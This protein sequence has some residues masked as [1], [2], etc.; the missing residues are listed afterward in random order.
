MNLK[1]LFISVVL[2]VNFAHAAQIS[3]TM[4]DPEITASPLY[5]SKQRNTMILKAFIHGFG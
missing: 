5:T 1:F 2:L 3:F 4:D